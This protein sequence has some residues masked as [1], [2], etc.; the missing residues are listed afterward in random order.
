LRYFIFGDG[1]DKKFAAMF[2]QK[3]SPKWT[4]KQVCELL[5]CVDEGVRLVD[6]SDD[7]AGEELRKRLGA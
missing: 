3:V 5:G 6:D 1:N 7:V 4:Y 2:F